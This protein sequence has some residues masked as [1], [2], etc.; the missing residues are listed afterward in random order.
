VS[1]D[2]IPPGSGEGDLDA[3]RPTDWCACG[4]PVAGLDVC[5]HCGRET[6]RG[7]LR[8]ELGVE[9]LRRRAA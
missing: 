3:R 4:F 5:P 1:F 2:P 9:R 8:G 6:V 7:K